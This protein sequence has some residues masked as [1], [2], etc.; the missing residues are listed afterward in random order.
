MFHLLVGMRLPSLALVDL[1]TPLGPRVVRP[2]MA[3]GVQTV[4]ISADRD[5]LDPFVP[6]ATTA[7]QKP[8]TPKGISKIV[9]FLLGRK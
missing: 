6:L 9:N 7:M 8:F 3:H 4:V 1:D 2:L 5:T